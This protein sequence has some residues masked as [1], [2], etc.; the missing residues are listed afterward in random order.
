MTACYRHCSVPSVT[1]SRQSSLTVLG[2]WPCFWWRFWYLTSLPWTC[3]FSPLHCCYMQ[4][5]VTLHVCTYGSLSWSVSSSE[6]KLLDPCA[7]SSVPSSTRVEEVPVLPTVTNTVC[8]WFGFTFVTRHP[9]PPGSWSYW[10]APIMSREGKAP[11]HHEPWPVYT[12]ALA[13]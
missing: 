9:P 10:K 6:Q 7:P 5:T 8:V 13:S 11:G 1:I 12:V 3:V 4:C 2:R